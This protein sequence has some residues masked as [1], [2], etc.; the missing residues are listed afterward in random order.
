MKWGTVRTVR[1]WEC[2]WC[3]LVGP[4]FWGGCEGLSD[5]FAFGLDPFGLETKGNPWDLTC[6]VRTQKW[7]LDCGTKQGKLKENRQSGWFPYLGVSWIGT[8]TCEHCEHYFGV[9]PHNSQTNGT[10]SKRD[11]LAHRL[12]RFVTC[13]F[14][15]HFQIYQFLELWRSYTTLRGIYIYI[16]WLTGYIYIYK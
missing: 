14:Q 8:R 2:P 4:P 13:P 1:L 7:N 11:T 16:Y 15:G 9:P 3:F 6:K 12:W 5:L 10:N